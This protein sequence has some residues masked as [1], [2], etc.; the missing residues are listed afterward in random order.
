MK[1]HNSQRHATYSKVERAERDMKHCC[2]HVIGSTAVSQTMIV[3]HFGL[4]RC[5][6]NC[7]TN[8]LYFKLVNKDSSGRGFNRRLKIIGFEK[9]RESRCS[10]LMEI[11]DC[12]NNVNQYFFG[13]NVGSIGIDA[14]A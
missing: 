4:P 12:H 14:F 10:S 13:K 5:Y 1:T 3:E 7:S 9:D 2:S 8:V 6:P 11:C